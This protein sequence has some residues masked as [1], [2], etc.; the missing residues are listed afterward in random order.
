MRFKIER[1][2]YYSDVEIEF[3]SIASLP[4]RTTDVSGKLKFVDSYIQE[5]EM[6][7]ND[8]K[9]E[10]IDTNYLHAHP[11]S[12]VARQAKSRTKMEEIREFV[13]NVG[14]SQIKH[15]D[16]PDISTS[17]I[18]EYNTEGL[19]DMAFPTIFPTGDGD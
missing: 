1:D 17:P 15:V 14:S 7:K 2:K 12:F 10:G 16:W 3:Q 8:A 4:E 19:F 5:Q 11:S 13:K 18:N 9:L 6:D